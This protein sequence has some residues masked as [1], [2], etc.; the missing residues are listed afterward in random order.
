MTEIQSGVLEP[1]TQLCAVP[2]RACAALQVLRA[3]YRN[4]PENGHDG[5]HLLQTH[6][7]SCLCLI[8]GSLISYLNCILWLLSYLTTSVCCTSY[9]SSLA[10]DSLSLFPSCLLYLETDVQQRTSLPLGPAPLSGI[11]SIQSVHLDVTQPPVSPKSWLRHT[12]SSSLFRKQRF[13]QTSFPEDRDS[14]FQCPFC[15]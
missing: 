14:I 6:L 12:S 10:L 1:V 2:L 11:L 9:S 4:W 15:Y 8:S 5:C 7:L 13:I 3:V